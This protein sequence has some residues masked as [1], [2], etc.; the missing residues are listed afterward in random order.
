MFT[1]RPPGRSARRRSSRSALRPACAARRAPA[2]GCPP[3]RPSFPVHAGRGAS[4][5]ASSCSSG[6]SP[7]RR[8]ASTTAP[9]A[10][11]SSRIDAISNGNRN[12]VRN[13]CPIEPGR[14]E[15]GDV[16]RA[17]RV[18][19]LQAGAEH[20]DAQLDRERQ[21]EQRPEHPQHAAA[22]E[23]LAAADVGDHEHV[24]DHHRAGVHD[25]LGGGDEL[26]AQQQEQRG[27]RDQVEREREHAV[28]RVAQHHDAERAGD[29]ADRGDEEQDRAHSPSRRRACARSA[30]PAASPW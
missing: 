17:L 29:R 25:H 14:P 8:R 28:E 16:R 1:S 20:R 21:R 13:S 22:R 11:T 7:R 6:S 5:R 30:R 9:T 15:A 10:A 26:G 18:D 3:P 24:Q 12:F 19:A 2:R 23:L 27:E 4:T